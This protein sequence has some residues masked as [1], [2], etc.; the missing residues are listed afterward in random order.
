MWGAVGLTLS[1]S[2]LI[3]NKDAEGGHLATWGTRYYQNAGDIQLHISI[4]AHPSNI[5]SQCLEPV[6]GLEREEQTQAES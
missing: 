2:C 6:G 4:S 1:F 3:S 5:F